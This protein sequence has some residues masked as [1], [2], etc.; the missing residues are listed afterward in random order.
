MSDIASITTSHFFMFLSGPIGA[1]VENRHYR[2]RCCGWDL[3]EQRLCSVQ[4]TSCCQWSDERASWW[5]SHEVPGST[6]ITGCNDDGLKTGH[7]MCYNYMHIARHQESIWVGSHSQH[8]NSKHRKKINSVS[9]S[10]PVSHLPHEVHINL[11]NYFLEVTHVN[12]INLPFFVLHN[13]LSFLYVYVALY[14]VRLS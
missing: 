5:T 6:G 3:C 13:A 10:M 11:D 9:F 7:R 14:H 8:F 1:G 12:S 2:G 4:S